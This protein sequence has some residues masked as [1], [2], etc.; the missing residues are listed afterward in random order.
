MT[1]YVIDGQGGGI[2]RALTERL[3]AALSG[4][5][6]TAVGSNAMATAAML[7]AGADAGATGENA[8]IWCCSQAGAGDIIAGPLGIVLA[9]SMLGEFSPAMAR[10]VA[11]SRA[12]KVLIP[13]PVTRCHATIAGVPEKSLGQ[14]L[15][16]AVAAVQELGKNNKIL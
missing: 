12:H 6:V 2:G 14:Y 15:D 10:A 3:K 7:K 9:N 16:D 11:E 8:L 13:A 1:I 4:V 5:S